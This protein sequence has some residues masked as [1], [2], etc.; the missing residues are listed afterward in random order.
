[1]STARNATKNAFSL[2]VSSVISYGLRF[3]YVGLLARY[4]GSVGIGK[5]STATSL[6]PLLILLV[7]FGLDSLTIRDVAHD[8]ARAAH[9]V[10]HIAIIR[11]ALTV[12][13]AVALPIFLSRSPYPFE[14]RVIIIIYFAAYVFDAF[15]KLVR[16]IFHA[17]Q[18][19]EYGS[20]L[21][22]SRDILNFGISILGIQLGWPLVTLVA[23]SAVAN[24]FKVLVSVVVMRARFVRPDLHLDPKL[25]RQLVT[26]A[27]PFFWIVCIS[28]ASANLSPAILSW[29]DRAE[30]VGL[31]SAAALPI[32]SLL[33]LP[34]VFYE[35]LFPLFSQQY[36]SGS[37]TLNS[38]YRIAYKLLLLIGFPMGAG[39]I[40]IANPLL[41]LTYGSG[42]EEAV[43]VLNL[44]AVQL[45]T[46]VSYVN[47][48]FL[49]AADHQRLFALLRTGS[50]AVNAV[51]SFVLIPQYS[52]V[53]A[54]VAVMIPTLIEFGLYSFL[55]F[56]YVETSF[57]W[58]S[59][60]KIS[61]S[62]AVMAG[63]GYLALG[64]GASPVL[65]LLLGPVVYVGAI[66]ATRTVTYEEW[67]AA[68]DHLFPRSMDRCLNRLE[69]IW[70]GQSR[71]SRARSEA[72]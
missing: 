57:P 70:A 18:K 51:L 14:T 71:A 16:S 59:L 49:N 58:T 1:M 9:Y 36:R 32:T 27:I 60:L 56:H 52:Y 42:F 23:V 54:A 69:R 34:T 17:F 24:L 48:A 66:A 10:T 53:G 55:C 25:F 26:T 63:I 67:R 38:S 68:R 62:T 64:Y 39:I 5:V 41:S 37:E 43:V 50:I 4:V 40:L 61:V 33:L 45:F 11:F 21:D 72:E 28:V 19:M 6:V 8:K 65:V 2:L 29:M 22:F 35:T 13:L 3:V 20:V 47:G 15:Y 46:M 12:L 30:S 31:Y 44:L 7:N